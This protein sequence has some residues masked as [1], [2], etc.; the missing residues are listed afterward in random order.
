MNAWGTAEGNYM[1]GIYRNIPFAIM[2]GLLIYWSYQQRD[3]AGLK[4]MWLL[5]LLSFVFYIPVVLWSNTFPIVGALMMPKTVAYLMIVV[6]GYKYYIPSFERIN[7]LGLA[8]TNMIMGLFVGVF[9]REFTK[10]YHFTEANHLGK[11]HGHLL[12]LGFVVMILLYLLTANMNLEQIHSLKKPI[13]I[14]EAGLVF[15]IVTMFVIGVYE[16]VGMG[17]TTINMHA[18]AGMSGLGHILLSIGLV[19][20]L[21]KIYQRE[22]ISNK[23]N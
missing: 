22:T 2:G 12:I 17:E 8:F 11:M 6:L 18:M 5:I 9:Y 13:H 19:W 21:A 16:V 1:F 14:L 3:K 20:T 15:T 23:S 7:L 10:F 4:H